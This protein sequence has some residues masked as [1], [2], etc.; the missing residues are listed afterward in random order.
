MSRDV[1]VNMILGVVVALLPLFSRFESVDIARTSKDH[2][3]CLL[4]IFLSVLLDQRKR[5][6][7][8][9][10]WP[11]IAFMAMTLMFNYW[12]SAS[13]NVLMQSFYIMAGL[14]FFISY[15]E[16]HERNSTHYIVNG[17]AVG[18]IIQSILGIGNALGIDIY[19]TAI[20]FLFNDIHGEVT[21]EH[22]I[23]RGS[24]GNGNLLASYLSV[25]I[26]SLFRGSW[27]IFLPIVLSALILTKSTMGIASF[28]AGLGY[29]VLVRQNLIRKSFAY[30]S[31]IPFMAIAFF[32]GL[33]GA[34]SKRFEIWTKSFERVDLSHLLIGAGPGW[35]ADQ[36]IQV[37]GEN[38]VVQEHNEFIAFFNIFGLLG[39]VLAIPLIIRFLKKRNNLIFS[40]MLF[41]A[42]I[43]AYGHFNL[44]QSTTALIIII[45]AC[46]CLAERKSDVCNLE[47]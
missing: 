24:L 11:L 43:N 42:F 12:N 37:Y 22:S 6:L 14:V 36:R 5:I 10:A 7:P 4:F 41:A 8:L 46:V 33:N 35:F 2:L 1:L 21:N 25:G 18:V 17:I 9:N 3:L 23:A 44:H 45:A 19:E 15:Y 34:D 27:F 20:T 30:L 16:K 38:I 39:I 32:H 31:A 28:V 40:S 47:R 29:Y 13:I 26:Y